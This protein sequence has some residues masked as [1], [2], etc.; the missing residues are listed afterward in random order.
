MYTTQKWV[1]K[2]G[3]ITRLCAVGNVPEKRKKT[4][5]AGEIEESIVE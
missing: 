3:E 5:G 2:M 4:G 1:L